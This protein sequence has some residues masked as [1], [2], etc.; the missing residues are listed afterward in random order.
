MIK[1]LLMFLFLSTSCSK[2]VNLNLKH[3]EKGKISNNLL[4]LFKGKDLSEL[5]K[6]L[7]EESKNNKLSAIY[8]DSGS[9]PL[10][11]ALESDFDV[12]KKEELFVKILVCMCEQENMISNFEEF[13]KINPNP[14][15]PDFKTFKKDQIFSEEFKMDFIKFKSKLNLINLKDL[16]V[17]LNSFNNQRKT[18]IFYAFDLGE[19]TFIDFLIDLVNLEWE[20]NENIKP[21][22]YAIC[23]RREVVKYL[24]KMKYLNRFVLNYN[25]DFNRHLNDP[26]IYAVLQGD[27]EI[28]NILLL[29][30]CNSNFVDEHGNKAI[31][32]AANHNYNDIVSLLLACGG[33]YLSKE[34]VVSRKIKNVLLKQLLL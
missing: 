21:L 18:L 28:V 16:K 26:L 19:E 14:F 25:S 8:S 11:L 6:A 32:L 27:N 24:N 22:M 10:M 17:L 9:N 7:A 29:N 13:T 2:V 33:K 30:G 3:I 34:E 31:L 12:K 5:Y 4:S 23:E 15:L 1:Y 20:N